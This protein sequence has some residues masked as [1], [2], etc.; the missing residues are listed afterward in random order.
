MNIK[1]KNIINAISLTAHRTGLKLK[2]HSPEILM[3]SGVIGVVASTV[4]AC[5]AT[6]K[7]SEITEEA[8]NAVDVIHDRV[9]NPD[10]GA[11]Y[12]EEDNKK[13]LA[14]VYAQTGL[15]F[16][17]LYGPSVVLGVVSLSCLL[18][19]HKILRKRNVALAAAYATIDKGFRE[20][21]SRVV[22]RFG[23]DIDRELRYNIKAEEVE[24]T[25]KN[26]DGTETVVKKTVN[27]AN[28]NEYSDYARIFDESCSGW[29]KDP[30]LNLV[31][32][33]QQQNY[34]NDLLKA[35]GHLFLNEVYDLLGFPRSKAGQVVGWICDEECG[36]GDN[37]VD[38]GLYDNLND[39]RKRAFIN[40]FERS[41]LLDFNVDGNILDMI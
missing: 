19:S 17:K 28:I 32:L 18:T 39:E 5:K 24:E 26:E 3:V 30:E 4:M 35:K 15:R 33:K 7:V 40:G 14:I 8:K 16:V 13:D 37:Y 34:A 12:T 21:R 36:I 38:F 25:V 31:F 6:T 11:E 9:N 23:K 41:V 10:T 27:V 2:K 1:F 20:Y 29:E 22:E